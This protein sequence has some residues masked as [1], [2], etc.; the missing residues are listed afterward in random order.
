VSD[1]GEGEGGDGDG[2]TLIAAEAVGCLTLD[3]VEEADVVAAGAGHDDGVATL[4][5][6][7]LGYVD[8]GAPF[9]PGG[10]AVMFRGAA[11]GGLDAEVTSEAAAPGGFAVVLI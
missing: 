5:Q 3:P 8:A 7:W 6:Q 4:P 1:S 9:S 2:V 11:G 10:G